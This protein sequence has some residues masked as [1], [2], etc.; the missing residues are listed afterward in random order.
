MAVTALRSALTW[1]LAHGMSRGLLHLAS[2]HG[3]LI[4]RLTTDGD[5]RE[6]PFEAYEELRSRGQLVRGR[7]ISATVDHALGSQVLR[8]PDVTVAGGHAE[9]PPAL[10][11][12][13]NSL[14]DPHALSPIDPPSLLAV[15]PPE[16]TRMR[17]LVAR[18]FTPRAVARMEDTVQRIADELLT[19][20]GRG[21]QRV[22]LV[23]QF[24]SL[25]P[26]AV[27]AELLGIPA[28]QRAR[29]LALGNT[30][31]VT[32]DPG[33]SW[34]QF[35]IADAALRELHSWFDD[36]ITALRRKPG[37]DLLSRLLVMDDADELTDLELR[38]TGLLLLGAGFE[39]TVNLIGNAVV[40]LAAHPAQRETV[41][42]DPSRWA[43][44]VEEVLRFDSPVQLTLRTPVR[45]LDIDGTRLGRGQA[46]LVML[47]GANRDPAVFGDPHRFDVRRPNADQHISFSAGV[48]YCLGANLAR[49]EARVALRTLYDR[50]PDLTLADSPV[51][52]PT[53]VLRG[54]EHLPVDL[55]RVGASA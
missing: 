6:N 53:R 51:R 11:R 26:L 36:H 21:P 25:L 30:A 38:A 28:H 35:R 40:Q 52:R 3:D 8:S 47:G 17:K 33:L 29:L 48:H 37:E 55:G 14:S 18:A 42:A 22:D 45:D 1:S 4:A 2:R 41:Q 7:L 5:L 13:L 44:A 46:V 54:Y 32:L 27:I 43:N 19:D 20:L 31:A 10:L 15:D 39:T 12:I 50:F 34:R 49:L 16:H 9:L 23:D 24:A